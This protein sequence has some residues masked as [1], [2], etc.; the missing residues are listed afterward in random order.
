M[1]SKIE[2]LITANPTVV[3]ERR[4]SLPPVLGWFDFINSNYPIRSRVRLFQVLKLDVLVP[5]FN[6]P[7]SIIS[8]P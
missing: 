7:S 8:G 2:I 5:Y 4:S 1:L 6:S 3:I